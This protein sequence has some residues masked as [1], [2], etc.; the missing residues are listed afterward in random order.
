MRE[1]PKSI[2]ER[3]CSLVAFDLHSYGFSEMVFDTAVSNHGDGDSYVWTAGG[4]AHTYRIERVYQ[5]AAE[6]GYYAFSVW[7]VNIADHASKVED[8]FFI[9]CVNARLYDHAG[10]RIRF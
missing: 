1:V 6:P 8:S 4:G 10:E 7:L 2:S 3:D 5:P 9:D